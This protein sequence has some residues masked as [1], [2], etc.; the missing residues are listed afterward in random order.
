MDYSEYDVKQPA[1]KSRVRAFADVFHENFKQYLIVGLL[2][3]LAMAPL[4]FFRYYVIAYQA[5]LKSAIENGSVAADALHNVY[6]M[7]NLFYA[8]C[9]V[10]VLPIALVAAG[11]AKAV[12]Y[13]LWQLPTPFKDNFGEGVKENAW[14]FIAC[15]EVNVALCWLCNFTWNSNA[16]YE[17]WYYLPVIVYV[18]V[19]L[20]M[21]LWFL[22]A[23]TVYTDGIGVRL[24]NAFKLSTATLV[25]SLVATVG[26]FAPLALLFVAEGWVQII[27][28]FLYAV[29]W[30]VP[31]VLAWQLFTF[32]YFDKYVNAS[33]FPDL[34]DKG[35]KQ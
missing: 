31:S 26:A 3:A 22:S 1:V 8:A 35:L 4:V 15:F 29:I 25:P 19:L 2:F 30:L 24:V 27:V 6:A 10:L 9:F 7:D 28:P 17:L 32:K 34:V 14:S 23:T 12:K 13:T 21:S 18:A 11:C 5:E 33:A 16:D 20:P